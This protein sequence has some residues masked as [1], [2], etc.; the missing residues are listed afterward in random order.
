MKA[1]IFLFKNFKKKSLKAKIAIIAAIA[2]ILA[3]IVYV[4]YS[5]FKPDPLGEY[6]YSD[7]AY[8][9]ITDTLD[10]SGTVESGVSENFTAV[11]GVTVQEVLVS[12][13]DRV[14]KGDKLATFDVSGA[15]PYLNSAK[16]EYNK[17]LADYN[18][19]KTQTND[20]ALKKQQ[21]T[22]QIDRKNA[23]L[24]ALRNEIA[25][26]EKK[27]S[28]TEPVTQEVPISQEQIN[29][30]AAQMAQ[31]GA[32]A[33]QIEQFCAAASQ[34]KIP[35]TTA[36]TTAAQELMRK[37]LDLAQ[38]ASEL[39]ALQAE[40]AVTISVSSDTM[41]KALKTV[42]DIKKANYDNIKAVVDKMKNGWYAENEGIVTVVNIKPGEKFAAV[43]EKNN[44]AIDISALLGGQGVDE[45][46]A[47]LV[48]SLLGGNTSSELGSGITLESYDD[49]IVSV[50]V[51][52]ADLLK[53]KTGMEAVVTSVGQTY[54]GEV[55]Y[56]GATATEDGSF[57]IGS[58]MGASGTSGAVIKVKVKNPDEKVVIG[59]DVDIKIKLSTL[60]DV[61]KVPVESV[62][63]VNGEYFVFVVD[64][65]TDTVTKRVI[66][67]GI[68]DD[69]SYQILDGLKEGETVVKI[70]SLE[71]VD[72]TKIKE[73]SLDWG[74]D[75]EY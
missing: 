5:N 21:L 56:V 39:T 43:P 12:V 69:I 53:V 22:A 36:D 71:F 10:V 41:L 57:N 48:Q 6:E 42:A 30:I 16:Q 63:N 11:N 37:N 7:V 61:L 15:M 19:A 55:V 18:N 26:L 73:K 66:T 40:N 60:D 64:R 3:L 9:S 70:P 8:G 51:G 62:N 75:I 28:E 29:E 46:T 34:I 45:G 14:K 25:A 17:A 27:V 4:L 65:A 74:V 54:E 13:G 2:V 38:L 31:N 59:F 32:T 33:E 58:L 72:G 1:G 24:S 52:K 67:R 44:S 50:T 49:L 47:S 23:Q 35:V 20:A 68:N